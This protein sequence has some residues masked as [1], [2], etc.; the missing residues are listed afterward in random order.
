MCFLAV[1]IFYSHTRTMD[2]QLFGNLKLNKQFLT[3]NFAFPSRRVEKVIIS[4]QNITRHKG[5]WVSSDPSNYILLLKI[6][7]VDNFPDN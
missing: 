5:K 2:I 3:L 7:N 6:T 4:K 1:F